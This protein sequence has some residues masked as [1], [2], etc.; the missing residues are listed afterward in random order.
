[1]GG[2]RRRGA[3]AAA[4]LGWE[5]EIL[6][7]QNSIS[8]QL[9]RGANVSVHTHSCSRRRL[10]AAGAL[11]MAR[12]SAWESAPEHD[13][14]SL[15]EALLDLTL[16][17]D[18]TL[19]H[20]LNDRVLCKMP[21]GWIPGTVVA[22]W[23]REKS[24]PAGKCAAY[25]VQLEGCLGGCHMRGG[26][27][28]AQKSA[29]YIPRDC[30]NLVRPEDGFPLYLDP[31]ADKLRRVD[32][33]SRRHGACALGYRSAEARRRRSRCRRSRRPSCAIR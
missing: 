20:A 6:R 16:K 25:A 14:D 23:Y 30:I 21:C 13:H 9:A 5:V 10:C 17:D 19:R 31:W 18:T 8:S 2:G 1:M 24:F 29:V 3:G 32:F 33:C 7:H 28:C 4:V 27:G 11:G 26:F 15:A 22:L 12:R